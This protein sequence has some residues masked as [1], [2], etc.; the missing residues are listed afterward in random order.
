VPAA[1]LNDG[2][3]FDAV[4]CGHM[5]AVERAARDG[6]ILP[7]ELLRDLVMAKG[8]VCPV[9]AAWRRD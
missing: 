7:C 9:P 5:C 6:D 2:E 8:L 3:H 1:L 4:N